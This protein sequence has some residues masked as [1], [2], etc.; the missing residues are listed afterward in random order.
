MAPNSSKKPNA[1]LHGALEALILK[2][3]VRGPSHGYAI[4]RFLEDAT[5]ES[6]LI[7]DGSLY[8]A[9]YRLERKGFV[10]AEWGASELGRRAKLY[11][12]TAA[13]RERLA[14]ETAAWREFSV[15]VSKVLFA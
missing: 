11:R 3:L 2:T 4:A 1:L 8:P 12:I 5:D 10:E 15:G 13:G 9:L 7:E 6:V 14:E